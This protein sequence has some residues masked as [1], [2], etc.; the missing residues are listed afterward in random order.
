MITFAKRTSCNFLKF[1]SSA[2]TKKLVV[3]KTNLSIRYILLFTT[4]LACHWEP[5][6]K[7]QLK[8]QRNPFAPKN[9]PTSEV[10]FNGTKDAIVPDNLEINRAISYHQ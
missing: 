3:C 1:L 6:R 9:I 7:L 8:P 5:E 10:E 4:K 2:K